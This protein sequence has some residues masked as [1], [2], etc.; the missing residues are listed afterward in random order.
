MRLID[1]KMSRNC[2]PK[3]PPPEIISDGSFFRATFHSNEHYD[4]TGFE[5]VYQFREKKG[6]ISVH[7]R[8]YIIFFAQYTLQSN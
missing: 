4:G 7:V 5:A 2:G 8:N 3:E 1:R 6:S